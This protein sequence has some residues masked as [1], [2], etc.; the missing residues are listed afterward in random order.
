MN[1]TLIGLGIGLVLL[2][3]AARLVGLEADPD[4]YGWIGFYVDEGRWTDVAR[5]FGLHGEIHLRPRNHNTIFAPAFE[6]GSAL[7]F[8]LLGVGHAAAR[9]MPALCGAA[10]LGILAAHLRRRA[11]PLGLF[12]GVA[13]VAIQ[14]D[15]VQLSR[16]AVPETASMLGALLTWVAVDAAHARRGRLVAAGAVLV[17]AL[18]FKL[19]SYLLIPAFVLVV[20]FQRERA[21]WRMRLGDVGCLIAVGAAG[22]VAGLVAIVSMVPSF[23]DLLFARV[24]NFSRFLAPKGPFEIVA[25]PFESFAGPFLNPALGAFWLGL[26]V[27]LS[28]RAGSGPGAEPPAAP[29]PQD[30]RRRLRGALIWAATFLTVMELQAYFPVRYMTHALVPLA[31]VLA[32]AITRLEQIGIAGLSAGLTSGSPL[33]RASML[34]LLWAPTVVVLAPPVVSALAGLGLDAERL[35]TKLAALALVA[36]VVLGLGREAL[37]TP[38][39]LA[40][41]LLYPVTM[42][43]G[44]LVV[45]AWSP[46][47]VDFWPES[48]F[49]PQVPIWILWSIAAYGA[50]RVGVAAA[51]GRGVP[52]LAAVGLT[53]GLLWSV[54][55]V[56]LLL[57]GW[58]DPHYTLRDA[59][60]DLPSR[61]SSE[62]E[63]QQFRADSLFL[64]NDLDFVLVDYEGL[65]T[66]LPEYVIV[67]VPTEQPL[68]V[69]EQRYDLL[70]AYNL[71]VSK[72]YPWIG[73]NR[74]LHVCGPERGYCIAVY[75]LRDRGDAIRR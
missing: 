41:A 15:L 37:R 53:V 8:K 74:A 33:R 31:L 63:I 52:S 18:S 13:L 45:W 7:S 47:G 64:G 51:E 42:A 12:L 25:L 28:D 58:T 14:A 30:T 49:G 59:A 11:T 39:G 72:R 20:L 34:G 71:H 73:E 9:L 4:Y 50:V 32:L 56:G 27:F 55:W 57:P 60:R 16:V 38:R 23:S 65:P 17:A 44:W 1:R 26:L 70:A 66:N 46:A 36:P 75:A 35:T 69:L 29:E 54:A 2:G 3:A 43:L 10:M 6:L 48:G 22:G 24:A 40:F 19:T 5:G 62:P 68:P 61:L 67:H 21:G